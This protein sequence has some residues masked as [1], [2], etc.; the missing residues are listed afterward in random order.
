[1]LPPDP[2]RFPSGVAA[3]VLRI[4]FRQFK[5]PLI[6]LLLVAAGIALALGER[7]D[8]AVIVGVLL[9]NAIV[10]AFQEGRAERSMDALRSSRRC[11]LAFAAA[12]PTWTSRRAT[13]FRAT[14]WCWRRG[15]R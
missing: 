5:S 8:A 1:M 7:A 10:G 14:C 3:A 4:F 9:T 15:T 6:Y 13:W 11:A 2:T 12:E